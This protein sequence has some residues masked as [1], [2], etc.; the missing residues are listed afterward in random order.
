MLGTFLLRPRIINILGEAPIIPRIDIYDCTGD[1]S[2]E[3]TRHTGYP[4]TEV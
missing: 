2:V 1:A 4:V 3:W